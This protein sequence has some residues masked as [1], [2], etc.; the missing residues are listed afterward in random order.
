MRLAER[1]RMRWILQGRLFNF[2][3][4]CTTSNFRNLT[5]SLSLHRLKM[6][7]NHFAPWTIRQIGCFKD[8]SYHLRSHSF[9]SV[10]AAIL[11][12]PPGV[13][14]RHSQMWNHNRRQQKG[15]KSF[16]TVV[17]WYH[18]RWEQKENKNGWIPNYQPLSV[19]T[20]SH[21]LTLP[22]T[23]AVPILSRSKD[24]SNHCFVW[25]CLAANSTQ[26]LHISQFITFI[27]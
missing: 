14:G 2:T 18:N 26:V 13:S 6:I 19:T 21:R 20:V 17:P 11:D 23:L 9:A 3:L 10:V 1:G 4:I 27:K 5:H 12:H 8:I 25:F 15:T 7:F 22:A 24:T 16:F